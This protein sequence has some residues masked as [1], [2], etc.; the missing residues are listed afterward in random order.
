MIEGGERGCERGCGDRESW[1]DCSVSV[2]RELQEKE[3]EEVGRYGGVR[4]GW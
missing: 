2:S 4:M 1:M 3:K